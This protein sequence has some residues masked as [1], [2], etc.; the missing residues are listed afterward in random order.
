MKYHRHRRA[1]TISV[2]VKT[3][4]ISDT[5]NTHI[6]K[7]IVHTTYQKDDNNDDNNNKTINK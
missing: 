3:Y 6:V 4:T 2:Y 7:S 5:Y 1:T